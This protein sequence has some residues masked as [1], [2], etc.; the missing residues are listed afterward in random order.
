MSMQAEV[1][2]VLSIASDYSPFPLGR[3]DPEDGP[4]TGQRF[5]ENYLVPALNRGVVTVVLDG[6][7]GYGSSFLEEV[8]GGLVR[9]CGFSESELNTLLVLVSEDEPT[10][11][12]EIRGYISDA[13][14]STK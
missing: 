4:F 12:K 5:R 11:I 7:E 3:Y 8:F 9:V 2:N 1:M 14:R 13:S 6:A 10:L